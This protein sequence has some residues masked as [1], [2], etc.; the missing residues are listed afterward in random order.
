MAETEKKIDPERI[1][2]VLATDC[3]STTTKAILIALFFMELLEARTSI[4][5][6]AVVAVLLFGLLLALATTDVATRD[7]PP[8]LVPERLHQPVVP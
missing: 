3:G 1:Q 8:L 7:V 4:R 2:T 5:I 6:T